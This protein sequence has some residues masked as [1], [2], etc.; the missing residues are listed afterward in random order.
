MYPVPLARTQDMSSYEIIE[1]EGSF[2]FEDENGWVW[3]PYERCLDEEELVDLFAAE[4]GEWHYDRNA[5]RRLP[6]N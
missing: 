1:V 3:R 6:R 5:A 2:A 4:D